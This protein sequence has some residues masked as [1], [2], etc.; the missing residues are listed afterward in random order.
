[1]A[2]HTKKK[3]ILALFWAYVG[4]PEGHIGW[5]TLTPF[6]SINST[7][8]RTNL[9][10]FG[11]NCSAFGSTWKS[12]FFR[13]GH[14]EFFFSNFFSNFFFF[15]FFF[16]IFFFFASFFFKLVTIYGVP[17]SFQN[18]WWLPWFTAKSLGGIEIWT[19]LY[20]FTNFM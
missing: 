20:V 8:P 7:N 17:R 16:F 1:M 15:F 10:N 13:V 19:T 4:Q 18:F 3:A 6:S 5:V 14:F 9:G 2:K 11:D 12:Q